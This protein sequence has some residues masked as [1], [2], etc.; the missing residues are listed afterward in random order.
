MLKIVIIAI[1][2]ASFLQIEAPQLIDWL[3]RKTKSTK[4]W[5][6]RT[7]LAT[8]IVIFLGVVFP[9]WDYV[10]AVALT[11]LLSHILKIYES[12]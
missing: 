3:V 8:W 11:Y 9:F 12:K 2:M 7:C 10:T 6:C 5:M 4:P 1:F